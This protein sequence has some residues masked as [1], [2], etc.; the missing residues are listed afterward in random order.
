MKSGGL[1]NKQRSQEKPLATVL[2]YFQKKEK[3]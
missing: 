3:D 1:E 2:T